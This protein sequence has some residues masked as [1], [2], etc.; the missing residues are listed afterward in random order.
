VL[1]VLTE[2]AGLKARILAWKLELQIPV[3]ERV[4]VHIY[5]DGLQLL[6]PHDEAWLAAQI[7]R[8]GV[9]VVIVDT[10]TGVLEGQKQNEDTVMGGAAAVAN[11]L[12]RRHGVFVW[13][14][15]HVR[16]DGESE[17]GSGALRAGVDVMWEIKTTEND[18]QIH[19]SKMRDAEQF[20][21]LQLERLTIDGFPSYV[22]RPAGCVP[23]PAASLT[24]KAEHAVSVLAKTFGRDGATFTEWQKASGIKER[25][26]YDLRT[27]LL[28]LGAISQQNKR[29]Y[30]VRGVSS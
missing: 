18:V 16:K 14:L 20:Q 23:N 24:P 22:L 9:K 13:F 30:A 15:H 8:L 27:R 1:Y 28:D 25:T 7:E 11:R 5:R 26:L 12:S 19:C 3:D 29:F 2:G 17:R 4:G 21:P 6:N 10:L